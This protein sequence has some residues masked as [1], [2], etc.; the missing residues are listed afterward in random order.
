M[1]KAEGPIYRSEGLVFASPERLFSFLYDRYD[2]YPSWTSVFGSC[3][4]G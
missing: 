3:K 2:S 1:S 4:V